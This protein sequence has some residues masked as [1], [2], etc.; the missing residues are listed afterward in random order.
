MLDRRHCQALAACPP[1]PCCRNGLRAPLPGGLAA[2]LD[3]FQLEKEGDN[4]RRAEVE[5][6]FCAATDLR[7]GLSRCLHAASWMRDGGRD[8]Q[9][10]P[11]KPRS[12]TQLGNHEPLRSRPA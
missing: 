2:W 4:V 9:R 11:S 10:D 5:L 12:A 8:R 7:R 6:G 1:H 3:L